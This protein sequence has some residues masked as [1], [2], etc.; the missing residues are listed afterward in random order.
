M[1]W[2]VFG[3]DL[4]QSNDY[5]ALAAVE[6]VPTAYEFD[7]VECDSELG[8]PRDRRYVV[9]GPPVMLTLV[10]LERYPLGTPYMEIVEL[11]VARLKAAPKA[12]HG[13]RFVVD[14]TGLGRPVVDQFRALGVPT[15]ALT[16]TGGAQVHGRD[17]LWSVPKRD[18]VHGLLAAFEQQRLAL[19]RLSALP[20]VSDLLRELQ[21]VQLRITQAGHDAYEAWQAGTHD[22]MVTALACAVWV[23][24]NEIAAHY[25]AGLAEVEQRRWDA[26]VGVSISTY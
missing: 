11:V 17:D 20:A 25:A 24:E 21:S 8:L 3:L 10:G 18:L 26:E 19:P 1:S 7:S 16:I 23:A 14:Y 22:D 5:S 6:A 15:V 13:V 4:G 12:T 2:L 9:E